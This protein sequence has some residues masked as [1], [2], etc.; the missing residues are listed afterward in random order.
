MVNIEVTGHRNL[1]DKRICKIERAMPD[2]PV[3]LFPR[4][5]LYEKIKI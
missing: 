2:N 5:K 3:W 4:R 1:L